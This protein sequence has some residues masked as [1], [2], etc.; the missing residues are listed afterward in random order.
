MGDRRRA[1]QELGEVAVDH[2]VVLAHL[3]VDMGR[4]VG[5][6]DGVWLRWRRGVVAL[7]TGG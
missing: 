5:L 7:E 2:D 4:R 6:G 3:M 1:R